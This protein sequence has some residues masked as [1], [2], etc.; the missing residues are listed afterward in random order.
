MMYIVYYVTQSGPSI[1]AELK[2]K[3]RSLLV[4][5]PSYSVWMVPDTNQKE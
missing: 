5:Q 3:P 2:N 1:I 4:P